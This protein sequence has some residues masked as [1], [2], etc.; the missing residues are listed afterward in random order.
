MAAVL[1]SAPKS[2]M[3]SLVGGGGG[4][5]YPLV[6]F[7]E[8][9]SL[10]GRHPAGSYHFD[11]MRGGSGAGLATAMTGVRKLSCS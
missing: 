6:G 11:A 4:G 5:A 3:S 7:Q 8:V 1:V 9:G 2:C 10:L